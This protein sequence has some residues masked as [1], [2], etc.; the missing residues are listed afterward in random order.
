MFSHY[1]PREIIIQE[2]EEAGYILEREFDFLP[3]QHF[4]IYLKK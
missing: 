1:V 3:D 4:T 2:M